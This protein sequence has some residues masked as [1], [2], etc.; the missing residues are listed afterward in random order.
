MQRKATPTMPKI[1]LPPTWLRVPGTG[2]TTRAGESPPGRAMAFA[3]GMSTV[4]A[5]N[6][7]TI[8]LTQSVTEARDFSSETANPRR[9]DPGIR[10][11]QGKPQLDNDGRRNFG[12]SSV[13]MEP[14]NGG[15][16]MRQ[17]KALRDIGGINGEKR[18][19]RLVI[20]CGAN[21]R[22]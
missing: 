8:L 3:I 16:D 12:G 6:L 17:G 13:K 21:C 15:V 1:R 9:T 14:H 5:L 22:K 2:D 20:F 18:R 7:L 19:K 10:M 4:L 11:Q